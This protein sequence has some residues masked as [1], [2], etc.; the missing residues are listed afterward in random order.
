MF[1]RIVQLQSPLI[2]KIIHNLSWSV[3]G[4]SLNMLIILVVG[5]YVARFLGPEQYGLLNYVVSFVMLF[6]VFANFSSDEIIVK[7]LMLNKWSKSEVLKSALNFRLISALVTIL[8]LVVCAVLFENDGWTKLAIALYSISF[9][10]QSFN[11]FTNFFVAELANKYVA[12][13]TVLKSILS[14]TFKV[15]LMVFHADLIWFVL[16]FTVD[17]YFLAIS[18]YAFFRMHYKLKLKFQ[19]N[20]KV[21]QEIWKQSLPLMLTGVAIII[22]DR[23]DQVMIKNMLGAEEL[24]YYALGLRII[25]VIFFIPKIISQTLLPVLV[26]SNESDQAAF[27]NQMQLFS[28][29]MI[30]VTIAISLVFSVFA[31]PIISLLTGDTY[32]VT[33]DLVQFLSWKSLISAFSFVS[34]QW[35]IIKGLQR[36]APYANGAGAILNVALNFI[37]IPTMGLWGALVATFISYS[38]AAYFFYYFIPKLR[39]A[40][41][42]INRSLLFGI[43]NLYR[44]GVERLSNTNP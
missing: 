38:F 8:I 33:G 13:S 32:L 17:F 6:S 23:I 37:L 24:G 43:P 41:Y 22:Y 30:W 10:A 34:G 7:M 14:G 11:V 29:S 40:A 28:D 4:N 31:K 39:P 27:N 2:Q 15:F 5:I 19:N 26:S 12:K 3:V 44:F 42:V 18:L 35:I 9:I 1:K 25:S 20:W 36:F 16:A 21:V